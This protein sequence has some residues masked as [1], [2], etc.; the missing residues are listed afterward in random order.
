MI[1]NIKP[2]TIN[3]A[4][5]GGRRFKTGEY[6][7]YEKDLSLLLP[8]FDIPEGKLQVEYVFGLSNKNSDY[9]NCIKQFQDVISKKY[10]FNDNRIYRAIISKED[11]RKGDEFIRFYIHEYYD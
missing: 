1:I 5:R 3:K 7:Q 9:D 10:N 2:L 6:L 4:W 8:N 11:V